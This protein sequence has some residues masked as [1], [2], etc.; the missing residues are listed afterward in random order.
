MRRGYGRRIEDSQE[1]RGGGKRKPCRLCSQMRVEQRRRNGRGMQ[2]YAWDGARRGCGWARP[3]AAM[4]GRTWAATWRRGHR[5]TASA[6]AA[7]TF[8]GSY[9]LG[10][11][12]N[13]AKT[14]RMEADIGVFQIEG[15]AICSRGYGKGAGV[16]S[17]RR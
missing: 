17:C 11:A 5:E 10:Y 7:H 6:M 4:R 15:E 12:A 9:L 2:A 8:F 1:G 16:G 13:A 3:Q 14:G